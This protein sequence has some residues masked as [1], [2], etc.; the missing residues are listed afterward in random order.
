MTTIE[1][2]AVAGRDGSNHQCVVIDSDGQDLPYPGFDDLSEPMT[3]APDEICR[4][5]ATA[6]IV[7]LGGALYSTAAKLQT[8]Q[9]VNTLIINGAECE[10]Y[11]TCDEILMRDHAANILRGTQIMMRAVSAPQAVVAVESDMPEARVALYKAI[12]ASGCDNIHVAVVNCQIP[13]RRR[14][15]ADRT[16]HES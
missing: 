9:P 15:S 2:R 8:H 5:I 16:H 14:A 13:G 10:P 1:P 11:I 7:G 12:E 3:M 6:G 4:H